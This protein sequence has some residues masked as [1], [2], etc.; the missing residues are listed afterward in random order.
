MT[1][2]QGRW[3]PEL[4]ISNTCTKFERIE[5]CDEWANSNIPP[6]LGTVSGLSAPPLLSSPEHVTV[7]H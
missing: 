2:V 4:I 5:S 6:T 7:G 1:V 3:T